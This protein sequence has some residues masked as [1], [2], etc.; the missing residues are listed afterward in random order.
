MYHGQSRIRNPATLASEF[1]LIVTTYATLAAD[2]AGKNGEPG[3]LHQVQWRRVILDEA[4]TVKASPSS[5]TRACLKLASKLRW[6]VTGTPVCTDV[7]DLL[8]QL[9]FLQLGPWDQARTTFDAAPPRE[10]PE[11]TRPRCRR[12]TCT[13]TST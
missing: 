13:L 5:Q 2:Q 1:D 3:P 8:G 4:H 12:R 11:L 6:A 9:R 10:P 7:G